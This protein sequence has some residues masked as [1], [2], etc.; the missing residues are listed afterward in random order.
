MATTKGKVSA[1]HVLNILRE[2]WLTEPAHA[3]NYEVR[4]R[5]GFG[6]ERYADALVT[7]L[8][9]SRGIWFAGIEVKVSRSDWKAE[10]NDP[11]KSAA[12]QKFCNYWWI[13]AP[14]GVYELHEVP[15]RWGAV[16]VAG[17]KVKVLKDAPRLTPDPLTPEFVASILRN[18]SKA[19]EYVRAEAA[20]K[21]REDLE[22]AYDV[23]SVNKLKNEIRNLEG[24]IHN[25]ERTIQ[26]K[27]SDLN[28][29]KETLKDFEKHT[30]V[31]LNNFRGSTKMHAEY[32][33]LACTLRDLDRTYLIEHLRKI[34]S[35]LEDLTIEEELR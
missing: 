34:T 3:W 31:G 1:G 30:G 16:L 12:I 8:W 7:S 22:K 20:R 13:A 24:K 6:Y 15:E 33:K 28:G 35:S 14:E 9:P 21:A 18:N 32:Y 17:S 11:N 5:T 25:L 27:D 26:Y 10:L 19:A 4:N 23:N 29:L 2:K